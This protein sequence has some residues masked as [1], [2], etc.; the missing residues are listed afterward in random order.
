LGNESDKFVIL[1]PNVKMLMSTFTKWMTLTVLAVATTL[2]SCDSSADVDL[3]SRQGLPM[4]SRQVV[5]VNTVVNNA[6]GV[7][8]ATYNRETR[9]L[10][11][12]INWNAL[13]GN[14]SATSSSFTRGFGIYGP[15]AEGFNG[16]LI[17]SITGFTANTTGTHNG[18]VFI[19]NVVLRE[20]DLINGRYYVSI[21]VLPSF[22][23]G[24]IR[25]QIKLTK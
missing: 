1:P 16:A 18:T 17:Q 15:A 24:A 2:T 13:P 23:A 25:G 5:P 8:N 4:E 7:I 20:E 14:P 22:P 19:D 6:N 21:P 3:L 11:Y 9:T 10:F 12:T